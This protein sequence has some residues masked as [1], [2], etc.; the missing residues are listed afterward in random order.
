[1]RRFGYAWGQLRNDWAIDALSTNA[2]LPGFA[3]CAPD[4][5]SI[6]LAG[7]G[8]ARQQGTFGG[9]QAGYNWHT[10]GFLAGIEADFQITGQKA[11][12]AGP[13]S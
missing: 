4:G 13:H 12:T 9:L 2:N 6:C 3:P 5:I 10:P 1:M 8:T 7:T 11:S